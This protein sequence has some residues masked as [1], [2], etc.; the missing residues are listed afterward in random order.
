MNKFRYV[1]VAVLL[2]MGG[3]VAQAE[4]KYVTLD[5]RVGYLGIGGDDKT[6]AVDVVRTPL[7]SINPAPN[8]PIY[9]TQSIKL[10]AT[11]SGYY[12]GGWWMGLGIGLGKTL[13]PFAEV[14]YDIGSLVWSGITGQSINATDR[15]VGYGLR[16]EGQS[17]GLALYK[18]E[19][20]FAN[21]AITAKTGLLGDY[22][23]TGFTVYFRMH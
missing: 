10:H 12:Y 21:S 6:D 11:P 1:L 22:T 7:E 9:V 13:K 20:H 18:R 5:P 15:Y 17:F 16:Y 14:S 3:N 19:Y 2:S 8:S 4:P 23:F